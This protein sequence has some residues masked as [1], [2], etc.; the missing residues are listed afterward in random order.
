MRLWEKFFVDWDIGEPEKKN[1]HWE[2]TDKITTW[3]SGM[4]E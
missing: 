3:S 4:I 1:V 2:I